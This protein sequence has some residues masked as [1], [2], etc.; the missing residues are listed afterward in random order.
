MN[1]FPISAIAFLAM[2]PAFASAPAGYVDPAVCAGCH[3]QVAKHYRQTAMA[4]SFFRP[5][6]ENTIE[7]YEKNNVF[8]HA[9]SDRYYQTYRK[10]GKYYQLRYQIGLDGKKTNVVEKEIH[11]VMGSGNHARTYLHQT[12]SGVLL[13]LPVGWYAE[14]GG[15][16]AMSPG[17]DRPDHWD[18]RLQISYDCMFCHNAYPSVRA[19][20]GATQTEPAFTDELPEGIDCQRCH[21]P[22]QSHVQAV[23]N[24]NTEL[25]HKSIVNPAGLT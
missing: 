5:R 4:K 15:H 23:R 24:G 8:Y 3:T 1:W 21:G 14:D 6:Q 16:W 7:D 17:Y 20:A 13:Q 25:T 22:G 18:F 19:D 12:P 2:L 10:A 11:Y 9:A